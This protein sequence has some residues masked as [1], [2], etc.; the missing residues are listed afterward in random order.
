MGTQK[1]YDENAYQTEFTTKVLECRETKKGFEL[2]L[3]QTLF[4][5]EEGGQSSDTG[6]LIPS[7]EEN[8]IACISEENPD[9]VAVLDVQIDSDGIISHLCSRAILPGTTVT[10]KIEWK[11]RFSDMQQH[12]GEHIFSGLV[13]STYGYHNVGFH[14]SR[15]EVT[16]DFDGVLTW[17]E[18]KALEKRANQAVYENFEVQIEYPSP[19]ELAAMSY[20]SKKELEGPVRI[21]TFPGY[22]VCACC[23]PHVHRTGEIGLIKIVHLMKYKGGVRVNLLCGERAL[24]DYQEKL[25]SVLNISTF[26]SAKTEEVYQAV[27]KLMEDSNLLKGRLAELDRNRIQTMAQQVETGEGNICIFETSLDPNAQRELVNLLVTRKTGYCGV[28]VGSDQEGYRY[29]LAIADGDARVLN[30]VLKEQCEARGGGSA[31]MT[32]GSLRGTREQIQKLFGQA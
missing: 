8:P 3:A 17:E 25:D 20:R 27:Q 10:G 7:Q 22:D 16:M 6:I 30:N 14:L 12:S 29:I 18:V 5:P 28:F 15:K 4:F 13:F 2:I 24:A 1:L 26:L 9:A 21:V 32:Q 11:K 23:A 31:A 19:K